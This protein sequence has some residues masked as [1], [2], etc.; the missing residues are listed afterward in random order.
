MS[1][2][3]VEAILSVKGAERFRQAFDNASKSVE[4]M[5]R[6]SG[7]VRDVSR[8]IGSIGDTLTNKITKPAIGAATAL[9]GVTLFKG[10]R[11]LVGIDT[12][13]AQLVALGHDAESVQN[14][15]DAAL[16]SVKGTSYGLDEAATT[17]ASAVA[18]GVDPVKELER[19]LSLAADT[20]AI[21]N[22]DFSEMGSIF[23]KVQTSSKASNREL[24][25]LAERGIPIYQFLADEIGTTADAVFD[26][27]SQG[28]ISTDM[29]LKA[30][31]KNIGG[32]AKIIG[33]ESLMA[34]IKNVGADI[35]RIGAAFLDGGEK[36]E[37]FFSKL[38]PLITDL[39]ERLD[40][41]VGPAEKAGEKVGEMF[42]NMVDKVKELKGQYD[43]LNPAIQDMIKKFALIAPIVAIAIG[44]IMK[45]VGWIGMIASRVIP[46]ITRVGNAFRLLG[47]FIAGLS[48]PV[49]AVIAIIT[50]LA[51]AFVLLWKKSET[52]REGVTNAFNMVKE[53]V[54]N[55]VGHV[56]DFVHEVF[57][58][59]VDWWQENNELIATT[60]ETVWNR[61][62]E[63][64]DT[65]M[66][67]LGPF[68]EG[69]WLGIQVVVSTVWEYI[70]TAVMVALEFITGIITATMHIINGDWDKAWE[71]VKDTFM[72]IWERIKSFGSN[73]TEIIKNIIGSKFEEAKRLIGQ[74]LE[75]AKQSALNKFNDMRSG[76]VSRAQGIVNA[77]K[78]KFN[79]AKN[80]V[81]ER[82]ENA[83]TVLRQKIS[84]MP[85]I[86]VNVGGQLYNAGRNI[87]SSL[88]D[89]IKS[90]ISAIA[91]TMSGVASTIRN[92][93]PFSPAK[94]GALK[95]IMRVRI[96]ESIAESIERGERVATRAMSNLTDAMS[97]ELAL[98]TVDRNYSTNNLSNAMDV[99]GGGTIVIHNNL[100]VD[101]RTVAKQTA[102]YTAEEIQNMKN[103]GR[104][105]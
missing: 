5:E 4:R 44:P 23:N 78:Q 47:P 3:S 15:M 96:A 21:A 66:A 31:E 88:V 76:V 80:A 100:A 74:K 6:V 39:R 105:R 67:F 98:S 24:Q 58:F 102:A 71:V 17:A 2:Y 99:G 46:I 77:V 60:A 75:Q 36:G 50:V 82:M 62:S 14:I 48:A 65:V 51:G 9:A 52:F 101:G 79:D 104:R 61:I 69:A 84:D 28:E 11:R 95:D 1:R 40:N 93:L 30:V 49:W 68:L 18:A 35:G 8:R 90:R 56:V 64:V 87:I 7:R 103:R 97:G 41:L 45:F 34:S 92:Y 89:G 16:A 73:V 38:K 94:V 57:G 37:G 72:K 19:Y 13:R 91:N 42:D 22:V 83:K 86:I 25:Q 55:A 27:A 59:L 33:E 70:K 29:F 63:V 54:I 12:A 43:N 32:A 53:T 26:M 20:A 10:F 85:K 81:S